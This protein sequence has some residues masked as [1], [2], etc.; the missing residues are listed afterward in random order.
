MLAFNDHQQ[1]LFQ[2]HDEMNVYSIYTMNGK[3]DPGCFLN[4]NNNNNNNNNQDDV[5]GAVIMA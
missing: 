4:N 3:K 5:Y 1:T 2:R